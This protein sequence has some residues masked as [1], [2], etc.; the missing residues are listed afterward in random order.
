MEVVGT[1]FESSGFGSGGAGR[2]WE[3]DQNT[4]NC[5]CIRT[6]PKEIRTYE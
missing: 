4:V 6:H 3:F 2:G 1:E 5:V